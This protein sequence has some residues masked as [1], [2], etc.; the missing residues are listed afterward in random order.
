MFDFRIIPF[1]WQLLVPFITIF[2]LAL[3]TKALRRKI[4]LCSNACISW[5]L[6]FLL[7]LRYPVRHVYNKS[8]LPSAQYQF[9]NGQGDAA[10]FLHGSEN[11]LLWQKQHGPIYRIWSGTTPEVVLTK[12]EHIQ[13]VFKD[14]DRHLKA[15]NNNSGY[16][17]GELLGKCVG[18]MEKR[19]KRHFDQLWKT[20][21]LS[22]SV[23]DAAQDLK[24]LPFW[25]VAEILYGGLTDEV[26]QQLGELAPVREKLFQY[27]LKGGLTRFAWS[28]YLPTT[29]N[30]DLAEFKSRWTALNRQA[31]PQAPPTSPIAS[32]YNAIEDGSLEEDAILQTLDEALFANLDVTLGGI[33]WNLVFLAAYP[34]VQSRLRAEIANERAKSESSNL[35]AYILRSDTLVAACISESS[36]LRPL[37]AF[38]VPQAAPTGR[39][40]GEYYFPPG[41]NF[42]VDS[43][44]LNQR[45]DYWGKD[46]EKYRP[47]RFLERSA[48]KDRYN[49]WRFGFG[50]RQC[51]GKF[52][53]DLM[54]RVLLVHLV[55]NYDLGMLNADKKWERDPE[56]WI[57]HPMMKLKCHQITTALRY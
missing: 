1:Q 48:V 20:S 23:I 21:S 12:P 4:A 15:K 6:N 51:M 43:H 18:L 30:R 29:A 9:P 54:I 7:T 2:S 50:P 39:V 35:D 40:V 22:K 41:T 42:I 46:A 27:F 17:L 33:S 32:Y 28:K 56:N 55:E 11:S 26:E 47:E 37:A 31:R 14:S 24:M 52:V 53:A 19:T 13:D 45:N 5:I 16:F 44:A 25:I 36:R 10:K 34:D 8:A 57:N 49:F 3:R 38:S